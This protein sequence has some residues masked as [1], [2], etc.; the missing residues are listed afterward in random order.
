MS[1]FQKTATELSGMLAAK[2]I[3]AVELLND[4]FS[5]ID[6]VE[7]KIQA[8]ITQTRELALSQAEKVDERRSK[9]GDLLPLA[10]IPLAVKDNIS[11]KG[12][13]LTCASRMLE[14]YIPPF[15]ATV[16]DILTGKGTVLTGKTNLDEFAM[17]S[18]CETS[19]FKKTR[20]PQN[21]DYT[22]GGS[23]GGSA[24]ALAAG[25]AIIALGTDTGGSA[26]LPAAYCGVVGLRPTYGAVSR[27][28]AVAF[29]SSLDQICPMGRSVADVA[30]L[31]SEICGPDKMDAVAAVRGYPDFMSALGNGINGMTIG[32][33]AE[34]FGEG[35][36][37]EIAKIVMDAV[38][39]LEREGAVVKQISL[40]ATR[41]ALPAYY[42]IS[43]AEAS[44]NLA[45]FDG[46]R[47][48][49]RASEYENVD[50]LI[51]KSRSEGFGDEVKR[52][53]ILGAHFLSAGNYDVYYKRAALMRRRVHAEFEACLGGDCDCIIS[54]TTATTAVKSGEHMDASAKGYTVD[55]C[56]VAAS[57]AGLPAISLPC[58]TASNGLPVGLQITG[59][60]FAEEQ[61]LQMAYRFEAATGGPKSLPVINE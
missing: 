59:G 10:G 28:G 54:P 25:E 48:G 44:S 21:L 27:Y 18:S 14:S 2:Q 50:E 32:I 26:R 3:S 39:V 37:A 1:L 55:A 30:A 36:D 42:I 35:I 17:G 20:N 22:P 61:I 60:K 8:Y 9:G 12:I 58:G 31:F 24:A 43:A 38:H 5:R 6:S 11:V 57:L 41:Y 15:S 47:F 51:E 49:H 52:R 4:V 56:T 34:Y 23:S 33:P 16:I 29:G 46:V 53:L 19:Y 45:R 40:P 7:D 13:P